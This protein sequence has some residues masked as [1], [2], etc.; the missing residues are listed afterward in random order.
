M[1]SS[2]LWVC[3][4][5]ALLCS[6]V[7]CLSPSAGQV[8][9]R[10]ARNVILFIA[11][12]LRAGSVN[13]DDAPTLWAIRDQGVNFRNSHSLFPTFTTPNASAIATG[14]YLGDTGDFG[15]SGY[16]GFPIFDS[17][18]FSRTPGTLTPFLENDQVLGDLDEHFA[19]RRFLNEVT[20]LEAARTHGFNTAAVG[21]LGPVA[22]QDVTQTNPQG[23]RFVVPT[24]VILDDSTGSES[25]LPLSADVSRALQEVGL[26]LAAPPTGLNSGTLSTPGTLVPNRVQQKWF[27][28]ATT[29][30]ILPL[31]RRSGRPFVL[32]YWSRDPD[33][34]QHNQGDSL[35]RLVPGINGPTSRAG[36]ANADANL[37]QLL[38]Y[39]DQNPDIRDRTDVFVTSDHGFSTI[40]RH[41]I[42]AEGHGSTSY[43]ATFTYRSAA[44][45]P[46]VMPGWLPPGFLAVDL[47]HA[48]GLGLF[49][50]DAQAVI[51]GV[52]RYVPVDPSKPTS[53]S[54]HQ[55][56]LQGNALLGGT[57][58]VQP[59][60]DAKV[61][62]SAGGGS[63]LIY[64]PSRDPALVRQIVGILSR[65]DYIGG[66][67]VDG[68]Y[69]EVP[70][71]LSMNA[72][73]LVGSAQMPRPAIVVSFRHFAVDP[74][75]PLQSGVQ[76]SDSTLQEGQGMHGGLGRD[77]TFNNMAAMGP[78]FRRGF[79][80][81]M[82]VSNADIAGT[83]AHVLGLDL[84]AKGALAG[85]VLSEA[86]VD[87]GRAAPARSGRLVSRKA[88][89][90]RSTVLEYQESNGRRYVD[91]ACF[92]VVRQS[93]SSAAESKSLC[94]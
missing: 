48:L 7:G 60:T 8:A 20:L 89:D 16:V 61:V 33:G 51:D 79:V 75:N 37:R 72:V 34:S 32:V 3:L 82:P 57:G 22:I 41:E 40:S 10:P 29:R 62:V 44:G 15:N 59:R 1:R 80:D 5:A 14:H 52:T 46:E 31:F 28:D 85:R 77:E 49:D 6:V 19:N 58:V 30:A 74:A 13:P 12:G 21:K 55:H 18:N 94:Q 2:G 47:A 36:V 27:A 43:A 70:G 64:I 53:S 38:D 65:Q 50:P 24:T 88:A 66:L 39:L 92:T 23:G 35:N 56:L 91:T 83:L 25:G 4:G 84:P 63:D 17:G 42:D 81:D 26:A 9:E 93:G 71:A 45:T 90:G 87:G 11:D 86:L 68:S 67:F 76:I 54:S 78:D 73:S 69:G